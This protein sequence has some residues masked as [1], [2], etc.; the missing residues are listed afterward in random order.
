M[1]AFNFKKTI[2]RIANTPPGQER[3]M[4]HRLHDLF[5]NVLKHPSDNIIIDSNQPHSSSRPDLVIRVGNQV[6]ANGGEIHHDWIVVEVKGE[7]DAFAQSRSR[8]KIFNEKSKY[9]QCGTE[10]FLMIDPQV[11]VAR[12]VVMRSQLKID[13]SKDMVFHWHEFIDDA[14]FANKLHFLSHDSSA[15]SPALQ[16]FR[17]GDESR[18][19]V[20]KVD[21]PDDTK[22][23]L[24][25]HEKTRLKWAREDFLASIS[26]STR[27]LQSACTGALD[28]WE[29]AINTIAT[30][31][32][33]FKE[34]WGDIDFRFDPVSIH[35]LSPFQGAEEK[36]EYDQEAQAL[37]KMIKQN[38]PVAKLAIRALPAYSQRLGKDDKQPFAA[39]SANLILARI[40]LMRFF[41][42]HNFFGNKKYVC[43]G[44]VKALQAF[45]EHHERG[46]AVILEAA[47]YK[48]G[49]LHADAF[50]ETD[51]DWVLKSE[52]KQVSLA[53]ETAMMR[54]S[55]FDFSTV[56]G[57]IMTGIYDRFL[58]RQQRKKMGEYY[59]PPT[60]ARYVMERLGVQPHHSVFDPACGSGTFL[61]EALRKMTSNDLPNGRGDYQQVLKVLN[62]IGG[63]DINP[64]SAVITRIQVLWN[65]LPLKNDIKKEGFPDLRIADGVNAISHQNKLLKGR[66][67]DIYEELDQ[68][69]HDIVVGNP[70]YVRPER[71]GELD[72]ASADFYTPIGGGKKNFYD[73]FVYKTLQSWCKPSIDN[74]PAG[75]MGFVLPLSFCDSQ[76]SA[77]L[78]QLFQVGK[79]FRIIEIVD[80]EAIASSVF[81]AAVNP[82]LLLAE[83]RPA[84]ANDQVIVRVAGEES[85]IPDQRHQFDLA[86]SPQS[87]FSYREIWTADGRILTKLTHQ[88]KAVI[89]KMMRVDQTV[90]DLARVIWVGK[91]R[92]GKITQWQKTLPNNNIMSGDTDALRWE[93]KH[94]LGYGAAE[95]GQSRTAANHKGID[96]YKGENISACLVEG[97]PAK[98][99]IVPDSLNEPSWWKYRDILP[100]TCF[101]FLRICL[102]YTAARFN[103]Q[104]YAF[105]NTA[106]LLFPN[107]EWE[108]FPID[109]VLLSRLYQFYYAI[110]FRQA[111]VSELWSALYPSNLGSTPMPTALLAQTD[112]LNTLRDEFL[113]SCRNIH[114]RS[115]ALLRRL[116]KIGAIELQA[117]CRAE[118]ASLMWSESLKGDGATIVAPQS[119]AVSMK[120]NLYYLSVDGLQPSNDWLA[121]DHK[122]IARCLSAALTIYDGQTLKRADLLKV[123]IPKNNDALKKLLAA[124]KEYDSGGDRKALKATL[125]KIDNIVGA[126]FNLTTAEIR[127]VQKEMQD[128][129]FL[130]HIHPKTPYAGTRRRGLLRGVSDSNRYR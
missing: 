28:E 2:D 44:G 76:N 20:I 47:Y 99:N 29:Q 88:R 50:D 63:N 114:N 78:R 23:Q 57:D 34:R 97:E 108:K 49:K 54:L 1:P 130:R 13:T 93:E 43:N 110:Y 123:A 102:G 61:L 12:P 75:R 105:L 112:A 56:S 31:V 67:A 113:R 4:Y 10:W 9:I 65:L 15:D 120:N 64:F 38:K 124:T 53:I 127:R 86:K 30:A 85:V 35:R 16:A 126:A 60:V 51:L 59:T 27:F 8:E 125:D 42:D 52:S 68:A 117:A 90:A 69:T 62:N 115:D 103:P 39:E 66:T 36:A 14:D 128:D 32:K 19:A 72:R 45:M 18:I 21:L 33:K 111:A 129:D 25:A 46:Y 84:R 106:T 58:D 77:P 80:L 79:E 100:D 101:A 96:Y 11:L 73:L 116:E 24:S 121:V 22:K 7:K 26:D 87:T 119:T 94:M 92:R 118:S 74:Q 55:H 41:E 98:K 95:R 40:L 17:N 5:T 48:G 3:N 83:K 104:K 37:A 89:D 82:I 122:V 71:S 6:V 91:N 107:E 70:P 81:D 109:A